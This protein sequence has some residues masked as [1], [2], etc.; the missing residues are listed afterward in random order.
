MI[1]IDSPNIRLAPPLIEGDTCLIGRFQAMGCPCEIVVDTEKPAIGRFLL[2]AAIQEAGRIETKFSRYQKGSLVDQINTSRGK[3]IQVDAETAGLLDFADRCF[4]MSNGLFDITTGIL[5]KVWRFDGDSQAVAKEDVKRLLP[6]IGWGKIDWKRPYLQVPQGMEIDLGGICKEY[7]AD[8]IL[9]MLV[10]RSSLSMLVNLGGDIAAWGKREWTVGIED[11][12]RPDRVKSTVNIRQGGL[13]TSGYTKRYVDI[14]G[15]RR[16]HIL[17]PRTGWPVTNP[18]KSVT[19]AARTCT[20]AGLWS[21]LAMLQG[22]SAEDY[23][24]DQDVQFWCYR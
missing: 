23:L 17:D 1:P 16:G 7:A 15:K 18:P 11:V 14:D 5:R 24:K 4:D 10:K 6:H 13:A 22:E 3:Q 19:V 21:T 8:R 20:E 9:Q 2:D 12:D